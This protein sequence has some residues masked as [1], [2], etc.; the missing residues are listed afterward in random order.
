MIGVTCILC[1]L[2]TIYDIL[3]ANKILIGVEGGGGGGYYGLSGEIQGVPKL[4]DKKYRYF[5]IWGL[6]T[7]QIC[8]QKLKKPKQLDFNKL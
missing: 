6:I 5:V 7:R 3:S 8:V 4:Q 2:C 1:L